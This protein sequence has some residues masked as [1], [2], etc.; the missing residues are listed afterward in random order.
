MDE[1]RMRTES[2]SIVSRILTTLGYDPHS[3]HFNRTAERWIKMLAEFKAPE[4]DS[5]A[6]EILGTEFEEE[7]DG[8]VVVDSI[9]F[10][11]L[12]AHH[13]SPFQGLAHIGYLPNGKVVGISKLARITEFWTH[14][15]TVQETA[16]LEIASSIQLALQPRGAAVVLEASHT[17]M[18]ARGIRS[19]GSRTTTSSL[20]G[21]F[22][23]N[24]HGCRDEFYTV[25][26]SRA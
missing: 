10:S 16:T 1:V 19:V 24:A 7:Y 2:E 26:R 20:T 22:I 15:I 11:S 14:R 6:F 23:E 3:Q 13:L 17:C 8:L 5:L 12:C 4:S 21:V 9:P 18:S 25:I